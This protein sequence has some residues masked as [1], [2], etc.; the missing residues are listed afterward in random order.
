LTLFITNLIGF[1]PYYFFLNN[2]EFRLKL[3]F[4]RLMHVLDYRITSLI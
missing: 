2:A 4:L 3:G 1:V